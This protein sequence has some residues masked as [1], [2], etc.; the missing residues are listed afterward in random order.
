ML[1]SELLGFFRRHFSIFFVF[2][3]QVD[4]I[5]HEDDDDVRLG[6]I[7]QLDEPLLDVEEGVALGDVVDDQGADGL[8]VMADLG[9]KQGKFTLK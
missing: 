6:V 3:R 9:V 7:L 8:S 5:A 4:F 2:I 1:F